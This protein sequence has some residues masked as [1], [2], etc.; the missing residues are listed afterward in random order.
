MDNEEEIQGVKFSE[1]PSATP[2]SADEVVGLHSGDNARFSLA[3]IVLLVRQG[4]ANIFVPNTREVNNKALSSDI[5]LS[6]SDVGAVPST[7]VGAAGGVASLGVD[8]KVPTSQLPPISAEGKANETTIAPVEDTTTATESHALGSIFYLEGVLYRALADIAIGGTI[9]VGSGG[10]ATQTTIAENFSR[11]VKLTSAQYAQLSAAEKAADIIYI[12]KDKP[13]PEISTSTPQMD[14]TG[15]AGSTGELSDA[16]HTHP[17]DTSRVPV[18]GM[19]ENLFRNWYFV[20]GGTGTGVFPVNQR[21][22]TSYTANGYTIDGWAFSA[23]GYTQTLLASGLQL[24]GNR[25]QYYLLNQRISDACA[26]KTVTIAIWSSYGLDKRTLV[27]ADGNGYALGDHFS[28][29]ISINTASHY[30]YLGIKS[31]ESTGTSLNIV[32]YAV[33]LYLGTEQTLCHNEGT[34]ANPVWVLNEVPDYQYELYK[35]MT[36]TADS[37]DT[38]ANKSLATE[39]E[40]AYVENGTTA[41]RNYAVG[42]YFC[43]NGKTCRAKTAIS[44]GATLTLNTNYEEVSG[45]GLNDLR[46]DISSI[47]AKS[48]YVYSGANASVSISVPDWNS[49]V[50]SFMAIGRWAGHY[51]ATYSI[52]I[53]ADGYCGLLAI[54]N[55]VSTVGISS[56]SFNTSTKILTLNLTSAYCGITINRM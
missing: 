2:E 25:H 30:T 42:E 7:Y 56:A 55:T 1:F 16:G 14:G 45:G 39:Q 18:Y 23:N 24:T 52:V 33:G 36:S 49:S 43:K 41:S 37:T 51:Y 29:D 46:S 3:N 31:A 6:A 21:G 48:Q 28:L 40:L 9:N 35:C 54:A 44:S 53:D 22:L 17:T 47:Q 34:D 8:G 38:Y 10:N 12:V 4:L 26:G 20:G 19:G 50:F 27:V 5:A 15:A 13:V 11:I 32:F